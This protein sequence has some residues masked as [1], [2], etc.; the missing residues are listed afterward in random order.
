MGKFTKQ[1]ANI[2]KQMIQRVERIQHEIEVDGRK[3]LEIL[4]DDMALKVIQE[5][6][7]MSFFRRL[8]FAFMLMVVPVAKWFKRLYQ[9]V[10]RHAKEE[11]TPSV[12]S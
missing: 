10:T 7:G 6:M 5:L 11:A 12:P 8:S 4:A 3:R 9:K 1:A 2:R